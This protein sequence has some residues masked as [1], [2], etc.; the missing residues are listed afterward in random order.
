MQDTGLQASPPSIKSN[1]IVGVSVR[2]HLHCPNAN[3]LV[4]LGSK[5]IALGGLCPVFNTC[6]NPNIFQHYFGIEFHDEDHCYIRA[7][8]P[9]EFVWCFGFINQITYCLSHSTY[10]YALA[11][12]MPA[13]TSVAALGAISFAS[14]VPLWC[15][16]WREQ[17]NLLTKPICCPSC[18]YLGFCQWGDWSLPNIKGTLDSSILWQH[19]NERYPQ[20]CTQSFIN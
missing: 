14:F 1:E 5:V 12:T 4:T 9:Y 19:R 2:Y 7:I 18:H 20:P 15:E 13:R 10:T 8:S 6:L 17:W 11:A 3:A 16:Q